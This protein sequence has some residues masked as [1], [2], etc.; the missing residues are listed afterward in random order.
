MRAL[1]PVALLLLAGVVQARADDAI[2]L[3]KKYKCTTCHAIDHRPATSPS[4]DEI[5]KK[6]KGKA[7]A[8]ADLAKVVKEGGGDVWGMTRDAGMASV[9]AETECAL[10]VTYN[11]GIADEAINLVDDMRN[12]FDR[13][14]KTNPCATA[15]QGWVGRPTAPRRASASPFRRSSAASTARVA[16]G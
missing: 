13:A 10:V 1:S 15:A 16:P 3:F 11:R 14:L 8:A 9:V 7:D 4:Y 6:Y 12:F 5:M 2:G